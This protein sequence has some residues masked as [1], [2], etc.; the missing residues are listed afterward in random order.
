MASR[1]SHSNGRGGIEMRLDPSAAFD[2]NPNPDLASDRVTGI[3]GARAINDANLGLGSLAAECRLNA[4]RRSQIVTEILDSIA[5]WE[6]LAREH[7]VHQSEI[8]RFENIHRRGSDAG[9]PLG[10][11][12]LTAN[13]TAMALS[14][15]F[16][17]TS[18]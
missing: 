8:T 12:P 4:A 18:A 1:P 11:T 9:Q 13:A 16:A 15:G 6:K 5:D 7:G 2:I 3:D 17:S 14:A 10:M